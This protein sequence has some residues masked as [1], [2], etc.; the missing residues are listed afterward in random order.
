M[1]AEWRRVIGYNDRR[2]ADRFARLAR[3]N[4]PHGAAV[5]VVDRGPTA[6]A[7]RYRVEVKTASERM[8]WLAPAWQGVR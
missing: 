5:R 3:K 2:R 4:A 7:Q 8:V 6:R 1:P